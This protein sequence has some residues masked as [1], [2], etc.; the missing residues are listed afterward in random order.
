[1]VDRWREIYI[2]REEKGREKKLKIQKEERVV[3]I[4]RE[5]YTEK[6]RKTQRERHKEYKDIETRT[7]DRST[8]TEKDIKN[9]C[10]GEEIY[11]KSERERERKKS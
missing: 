1:M 2:L 10:E 6:Y 8:E 9:F 5:K 7:R 4:R 11:R 3:D